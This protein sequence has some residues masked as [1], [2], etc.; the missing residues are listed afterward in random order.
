MT[1]DPIRDEAGRLI[2]PPQPFHRARP[3]GPWTQNGLHVQCAW[4]G[5]VMR[6]GDR[7]QPTSHGLCASCAT[8][9]EQ[10]TA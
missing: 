9:F 4:C 3:D 1:T 2:A 8:K 6:E 7:T 10:E 5:I